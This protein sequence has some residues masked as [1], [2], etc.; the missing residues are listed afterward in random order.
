MSATFIP[1]VSLRVDLIER[2]KLLSN[3]RIN[4]KAMKLVLAVGLLVVVSSAGQAVDYR[5]TLGYGQG[6]TESIIRNSNDSSV[7]IYCPSGQPN[8][9]AGMFIDS[10]KVKPKA[11]EEVTV[12]IIVDGKNYPFYLKED[13]FEASSRAGK[14]DL[15]SLVGA[16]TKS[17]QKSFTVEFPKYDVVETFSLLDAAKSLGNGKKSVVDFC[18]R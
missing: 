16:L 1:D 4:A 3:S 6:T 12:Q 5:W 15:V 17:R 9:V 7:N 14:G 10:T 2:K 13:Q 18:V 11:G 8:H